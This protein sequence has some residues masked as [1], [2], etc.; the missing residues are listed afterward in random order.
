MSSFQLTLPPGRERLSALGD[1]DRAL[2]LDR[3]WGRAVGEAGPADGVVTPGSLPAVSWEASFEV[4]Q[5][6]DRAA[7]RGASSR[8][9]IAA[10][11]F[12]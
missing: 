11:R 12:A 4:I 8:S 10:G 2:D 7:R 5:P 3:F 9:R 6:A 1:R